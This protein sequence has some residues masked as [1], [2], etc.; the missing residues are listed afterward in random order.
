VRGGGAGGVHRSGHV[1]DWKRSC[2]L[3]RATLNA[4]PA[5]PGQTG[6]PEAGSD[7]SATVT[8]KKVEAI[9]RPFRLEELAAA[10]H[11]LGVRG[12]SVTYAKGLGRTGRKPRGIRGAAGY[13]SFP[14]VKVE[15]VAADDLVES[16]VHAMARSAWTGRRGDGK[17]FVTDVTE[18]TPLTPLKAR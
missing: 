9:V 13:L 16:V 12:V 1:T 4:S 10:L 8:M 14:K 2:N 18:A 6:L 17:I 3:A 15:L 7:A 5:L 11:A